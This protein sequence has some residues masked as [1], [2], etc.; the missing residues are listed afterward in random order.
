MNPDELQTYRESFPEET[1]YVIAM[2]FMF[3]LYN[4]DVA[5]DDTHVAKLNDDSR[6]LASVLVEEE[7]YMVF[8]LKRVDE[9]IKSSTR[10][11]L[12]RNAIH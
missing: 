12:Q 11:D 9:A 3:E 6:Q 2:V 1:L 4:M 7:D 5:I 8:A 10:A